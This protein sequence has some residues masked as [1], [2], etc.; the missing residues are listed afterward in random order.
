MTRS[1]PSRWFVPSRKS[2]SF[3]TT[4]FGRRPSGNRQRLSE[5]KR[6][7]FHIGLQR[8]AIRVPCYERCDEQMNAR[9]VIVGAAVLC[10]SALAVTI[11]QAAEESDKGSSTPKATAVS[12]PAAKQTAEPQKADTAAKGQSTAG[13]SKTNTLTGSR[14]PT[15]IR[16]AGRITDGPSNVT[17][18]DQGEIDRS[19][20]AT[21]AEV[22]AR[23][24]G[25][26][27]K[28]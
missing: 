17:V 7:G 16:R 11:C 24:S 10:A 1:A 18:I 8:G 4:P 9:R 5:R 20:A 15:T 23:E 2:P 27:V 22:L 26:T 6:A 3:V 25:I 13:Q 19:G 12:A 21:V 14:I 28:Q